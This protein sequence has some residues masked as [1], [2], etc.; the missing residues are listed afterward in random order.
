MPFVHPVVALRGHLILARATTTA[1][2]S[3]SDWAFTPTTEPVTKSPL[4][5]VRLSVSSLGHARFDVFRPFPRSAGS[6]VRRLNAATVKGGAKQSD[7]RCGVNC[8]GRR[9]ARGRGRAAR[10]ARWGTQGFDRRIRT[11]RTGA[12]RARERLGGRCSALRVRPGPAR[13]RSRATS[14]S[15][16]GSRSSRSARPT[17]SRPGSARPSS[18]S[19]TPSPRRATPGPSSSSTRP[20]RCS[21]IGG[22]RT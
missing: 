15:A 9:G 17:Y 8:S 7:V 3:A 16:W 21:A 6:M 18:R 13:A 22:P 2:L 11:P 4:R 5:A 14:R 20:T 10:G 12:R 1:P 19:R